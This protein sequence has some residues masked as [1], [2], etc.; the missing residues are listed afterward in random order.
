MVVNGLV[1]AQID[2]K[3]VQTPFSDGGSVHISFPADKCP[4]RCLHPSTLPQ[5]MQPVQGTCSLRSCEKFG[6]NVINL[7]YP[8]FCWT[9]LFLSYRLAVTCVPD[10]VQPLL[11]E[12]LGTDSKSN[13]ARPMS[14]WYSTVSDSIARS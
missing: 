7:S 1:L 12:S 5:Q 11:H 9:R 3:A 6:M 4:S 8:S 10:V 2:E 13:I 14:L